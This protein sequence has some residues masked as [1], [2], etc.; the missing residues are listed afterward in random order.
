MRNNFDLTVRD[1]DENLT[2]PFLKLGAK[3]ANSAK[4]LAEQVDLIITCLPSPKICAEVMEG[5]NGIIEGLSKQRDFQKSL[6]IMSL[7]KKDM[8]YSYYGKLKIKC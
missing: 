3:V 8:K 2:K 5:K 7:K 4:D 6:L 1:L